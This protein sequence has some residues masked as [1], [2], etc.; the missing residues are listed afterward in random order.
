ML[1]YL[2][3]ES[4]KTQ[5]ENGAAAY[6]TSGSCCLDFF[7]TAGALRNAKESEIVLRFARAF[8]EDSD[9]AMKLLFFA[10]DIRGGL[11]ERRL[12]RVLVRYLAKNEP[13][14]L[15]KNLAYIAEYGRY[16]DL[17]DLLGT[18]C[19]KE[20]VALLRLQLE[21][22]MRSLAEGKEV[23][24]LGKWLPSVNA[25][26]EKTVKQARRLCRAF[27][28]REAE[29]R[30]T[31][32]ALRARIRIIEN[33]LRESDY[34]FDY[35]KQPSRAMYKY[36]AAF[37]RNDGERYEEYL[38][39]VE[40]GEAKMHTDTLA[41]YELVGACLDGEY[42]ELRKMNQ[43][44]MRA[45]NTAWESLPDF[46]SEE[47]ALAV[48]D[49][50]GSMYCAGHPMPAT[51]ALSLGL[52]IAEHNRGLFAGHFIEFSRNARLIEIKGKKLT[53]KL[54]FLLSF[55]EVADTNLEAVF[56]L[57]LKTA[58]KHHLPPEELP[59]R[60]IIIS[61]MEFNHCVQSA[62][63]TVFESAKTR[64]LQH[65]YSLPKVVFWNVA[66]RNRHQPVLANEQGVALVSGCSPRLF[67]AVAGGTLNPYE[68]MKETVESERYAKISA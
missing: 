66:S 40:R 32:T 65:G 37:M 9:T 10:R 67:S 41:P 55:N 62:S 54:R 7:A 18:P 2:K 16:D 36:R 49:T 1:A 33:S 59:A 30:R 58:V 53:D 47:N 38:S 25:S 52:Y 48:V 45:I 44:E 12:F 50:S 20:T 39:R 27:G 42:G 11:G 23:S 34:S 35:E 56:S 57:I 28:M 46:G 15:C 31:L 43:A 29:Y 60:L 17:L 21:E 26:C 63:S 13:E 51:V 14:A 61:D 64:F 3:R 6:R 4:E 5:T 8:A 24:L 22:D 19:E 68:F